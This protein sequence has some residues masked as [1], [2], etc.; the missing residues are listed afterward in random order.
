[1]NNM[2]KLLIYIVKNSF[3]TTKITHFDNFIS[4]QPLKL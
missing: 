4:N 1:M 2:K 3:Y